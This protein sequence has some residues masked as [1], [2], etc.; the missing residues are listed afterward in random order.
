MHAA[1]IEKLS[2]QLCMANFSMVGQLDGLA[3]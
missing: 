3:S 1:S 2:G